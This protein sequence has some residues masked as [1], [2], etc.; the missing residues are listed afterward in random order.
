MKFVESEHCHQNDS[1]ISFRTS[2]YDITTTPAQEWGITTKRDAQLADMRHGRRLP[3]VEDLLR[4][5]IATK[6]GL[7][8]VEVIVLVLYTGP[9]VRL[10]S[11]PPPQRVYYLP[12]TLSTPHATTMDPPNV[13][14]YLA[15]MNPIQP[16]AASAPTQLCVRMILC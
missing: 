1:K 14:P 12:P 9:M 16:I 3:D 5:D 6:A 8:L 11:P 4:S 13:G 15:S 7:L 2:N 10:G